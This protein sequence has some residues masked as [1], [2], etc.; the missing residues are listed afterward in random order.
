MHTVYL[1][2]HLASTT[3]RSFSLPF[4]VFCVRVCYFLLSS[5]LFPL[6]PVYLPLGLMSYL[7]TLPTVIDNEGLE[8][9]T[10][11]K[12]TRFD[13]TCDQI[14]MELSRGAL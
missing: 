4:W 9:G 12:R 11:P 6:S 7:A 3:I 14:E 8:R 1:E 13:G 2:P 5:P 10:I